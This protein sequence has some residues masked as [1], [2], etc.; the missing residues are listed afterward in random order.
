MY[1]VEDLVEDLNQISK[2]EN[3]NDMIQQL[4]PDMM[5]PIL[6]DENCKECYV[7]YAR[8]YKNV[9]TTLAIEKLNH[10]PQWTNVYNKVTIKLN[11]HDAGDI[12][13]DKDRKLA[14][15]VDKLVDKLVD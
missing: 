2:K 14:A 9:N 7:K 1:V 8:A 11:T 5:P 3:D 13:T 12:V 4:L 6:Y 15:A 10:H